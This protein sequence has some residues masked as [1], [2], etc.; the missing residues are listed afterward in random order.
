MKRTTVLILVTTVLSLAATGCMTGVKEGAALVMGAKGNVTELQPVA[1]DR[2]ARPLGAY[3]RFE[4]GQITD[5]IGGRTPSQFLSLLRG[6]FN[7]QLAEAKLPNSPTGKTLVIRGRIIHYESEDMFGM[8]TGPLEEVVV[9]AEMV[10]KDTGKVLG[11]ANC[12]GRTTARVNK[13]V[14]KKAEGLAKAFV[15]WIAS[16]YPK[17]DE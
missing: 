12:I 7:E 5:D 14:P 13:G 17:R 8:V 15:K 16:R 10:D 2:N 9:R 3:Q 4:L 1:A 6:K 11:T